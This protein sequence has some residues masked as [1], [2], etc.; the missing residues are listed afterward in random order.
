MLRLKKE[1]NVLHENG[2]ALNLSFDLLRFVQNTGGTLCAGFIWVWRCQSWV[3]DY[4]WPESNLWALT[5]IKNLDFIQAFI[6]LASLKPTQIC[7]T[8]R[9][10][11]QNLTFLMSRD[12]RSWASSV[13]LFSW[14]ILCVW[15]KTALKI[16]FRFGLVWM[17]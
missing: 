5:W 8:G 14:N 1:C 16:K 9:G 4:P 10:F 3:L 13:L 11:H 7:L 6:G 15:P 12:Y 2:K 17:E